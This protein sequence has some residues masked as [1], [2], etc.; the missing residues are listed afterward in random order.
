MCKSELGL[1]IFY[2]LMNL[3]LLARQ[4]NA[5]C[6]TEKLCCLGRNDT[7]TPRNSGCFCD[8]H[9]T[10]LNDCCDDYED[11]CMNRGKTANNNI[12]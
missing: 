1:K 10:T 5:S 7:C 9:C 8:Q 4:G 11:Y 6:L 2:I 3:I 12:V